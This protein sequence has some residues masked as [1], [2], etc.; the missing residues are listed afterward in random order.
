MK[1]IIKTMLL[2]SVVFVLSCRDDNKEKE[3]EET[4]AVVEQIEA[5]EVEVKQAAE[6]VHE[7]EEALKTA[8]KE[9]D[10]I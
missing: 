5:A 6:N 3:A 4:Q 1:T 8:M 9:L 7:N 2:S 10:S